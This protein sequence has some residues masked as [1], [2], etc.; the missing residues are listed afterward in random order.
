MSGWPV[1]VCES[2]FCHASA[3]KGGSD[4]TRAPS[5]RPAHH[6][7]ACETILLIMMPV[8]R[9]PLELFH[10]SVSLFISRTLAGGRAT[11]RRPSS[12]R[13][14]GAP[15]PL[16]GSGSS[17]HQ[18]AQPMPQTAALPFVFHP[19]PYKGVM[20]SL[21][22]FL[23]GASACRTRSGVFYLTT[24]RSSTP[25]VRRA[26]VRA[27][28]RCVSVHASC[29]RRRRRLAKVLLEVLAE[30]SLWK[31]LVARPFWFVCLPAFP[32]EPLFGAVR[33]LLVT[34]P[35]LLKSVPADKE[36]GKSLCRRRA[37]TCAVFHCPSLS[38]Q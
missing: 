5:Q 1:C 15:F 11:L 8:R 31:C 24:P 16:K 9:S 19:H 10:G 34:P 37:C 29:R 33:A 18:A 30:V 23:S 13:C 35:A 21:Y 17:G 6:R 2:L 26:S 32:L 36:G 20:S 27:R 12:L 28:M 22:I 14:L 7:G 3:G 25:F 38:L 4:G